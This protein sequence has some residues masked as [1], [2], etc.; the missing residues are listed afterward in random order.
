MARHSVGTPAAH[1]IIFFFS[2]QSLS[3]RTISKATLVMLPSS[4]PLPAVNVA[5]RGSH[6]S[7]RLMWSNKGVREYCDAV[8]RG[9][10]IVMLSKFYCRRS[11]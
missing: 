6:A 4:A 11:I 10:F 7:L 8:E 3:W 1:I 2:Q 5:G 9:K